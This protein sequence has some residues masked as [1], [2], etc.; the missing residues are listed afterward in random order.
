MIGDVLNGKAGVVD[1]V[2]DQFSDCGFTGIAVYNASTGAITPLAGVFAA[3]TQKQQY[4]Y[5]VQG[6]YAANIQESYKHGE[7]E[8][9]ESKFNGEVLHYYIKRADLS[10][11][12][13]D[14]GDQILLPEYYPPIMLI[15]GVSVS[16]WDSFKKSNLGLSL[17]VVLVEFFVMTGTFFILYRPIHKFAAYMDAQMAYKQTKKS[18]NV[19]AK[20]SA[21]VGVSRPQST[22]RES[23][24]Q[25]TYQQNTRTEAQ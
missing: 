20:I 12:L 3:Y 21:A 5:D 11:R 15:R 25:S 17:A 23:T 8:D 6:D 18:V 1:M 16:Q 4:S 19:I 22:N 9:V 7:S 10:Y 13:D 2:Q 24:H 14:N